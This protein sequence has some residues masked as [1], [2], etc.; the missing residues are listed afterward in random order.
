MT[1][2]MTIRSVKTEEWL[3]ILKYMYIM[4][5]Y[6]VI[7]DKLQDSEVI[8]KSQVTKSYIPEDPIYLKIYHGICIYRETWKRDI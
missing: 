7:W 1:S 2:F 6:I 5:L 3:N 4:G 8:L